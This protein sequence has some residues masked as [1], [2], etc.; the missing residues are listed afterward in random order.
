[1]RMIKDL[2]L[3]S[4]GKRKRHRAIYECRRCLN[5]IEMP[6]SDFKRKKTDTCNSCTLIERNESHGESGTRLYET[7]KDMKKRCYN[8][9]SKS[10]S[11]YGGDGAT[12]CDEWMNFEPFRDWA[13]ANGYSD[14]LTIERDL[15][16]SKEY[17]PINCSWKTRTVQSRTTRRIMSTNTSGYRGVSERDDNNKFS[18]TIKTGGN[19]IHLGMFETALEAAVARDTY[20][21]ENGY[22]HTLNEVL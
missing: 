2:G 6:V 8:K 20:V 18:A 16:K 10:Y 14:N 3:V 19:S 12:V 21:V 4:D 22:E 11:Y 7:W 15:S 1:M 17:S 9:K 5:E 13:K